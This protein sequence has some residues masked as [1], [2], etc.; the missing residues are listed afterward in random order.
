MNRNLAVLT[1]ERDALF[2]T[3]GELPLDAVYPSHANFILIRTEKKQELDRHLRKNGILVRDVSS[4]PMLEN[5]LRL[6][7]GTPEENNRLKQSLRDFF[8]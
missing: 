8:Q 4:Y 1:A 2:A 6:S 3:L 7:V 5:C